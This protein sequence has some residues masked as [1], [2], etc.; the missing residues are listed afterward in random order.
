MN[1]LAAAS[2]A[3]IVLSAVALAPLPASQGEGPSSSIGASGQVVVSPS[4]TLRVVSS[5]PDPSEPVSLRWT[6]RPID[7]GG[8]WRVILQGG[9]IHAIVA[10]VR[11]V[12]PAGEVIATVPAAPLLDRDPCLGTSGLMQ[13]ELAL[14]PEGPIV[15]G[16]EWPSDYRLEASVGPTWRST[17]LTYVG[18]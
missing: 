10:A 8:G 5:V 12:D 15:A 13:A 9:T 7:D 14:P 6:V 17:A 3:A 16:A 18:C 11:L 4:P 1:G 2:F